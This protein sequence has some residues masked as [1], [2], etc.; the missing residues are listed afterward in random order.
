LIKLHSRL[1]SAAIATLL[2]SA[3]VGFANSADAKTLTIYSGRNEKL[4][5]PLIEKARKDLKLDIQ[6]R[7]GDTAE[8]AIALLEEGKRGRADLFFAQDAG[9]LGALAKEKR[10]LQLPPQIL[11][12]VESRF[13]ASNGQWVGISG[14][15]RVIDYNTQRVKPQ[16]LPIS[17]WQLT[18]PKWRGKVGW[19]PTNGSF[20]SFVTAMRLT[21]GEQRTL[22]WLKAMKANGVKEYAKNGAIVEALGRGEISLG[23]V[24]NYY[25]YQAQKNS[26]NFPVAHHYTK[27]DM[28]SMVNVAGMAVL[29]TTDQQKDAEA[30]IAYLLRPESQRYFAEQTK[31]YPLVTGIKPPEDQVPLSKLNAPRID[32]SNLADLEGT[33]SLLQKAGV[34]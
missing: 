15:A 33:L 30:L 10:T 22:D 26:A 28:G 29:N 23:L 3:G 2:I 20:Q 17:V 13:R 21:A 18:N 5:G 7:Y 4:I 24:N 31:E 8:L 25:L 27:G 6:V 32:L 34:L 16:E 9:A 14:R 12:K 11:S 19:A 1:V